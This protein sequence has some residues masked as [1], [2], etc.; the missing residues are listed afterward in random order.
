MRLAVCGPTQTRTSPEPT[1]IPSH[2]VYNTS[3]FIRSLLHLGPNL[4]SKKSSYELISKKP[5]YQ[6]TQPFGLCW[7]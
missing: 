7:A 4:S 2:N 1:L 6:L 5:K 3:L